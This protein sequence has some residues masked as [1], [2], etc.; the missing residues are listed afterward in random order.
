MLNNCMEDTLAHG[1]EACSWLLEVAGVPDMRHIWIIKLEAGNTASRRE[2][3]Y[4]RTT[5]CWT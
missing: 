1:K 2:R 3:G 5:R 4:A